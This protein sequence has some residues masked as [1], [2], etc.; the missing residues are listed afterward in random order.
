MGS[1]AARHALAVVANVQRILAIELLVSAQALDFRLSRV[2]EAGLSVH[3][4]VG[5][6]EAHARIRAVVPH[7]DHDRLQTADIAAATALVRDGALVDLV[8]E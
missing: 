6:A 3:P 1:I 8:A 4:G 5:V 2:A 7:L